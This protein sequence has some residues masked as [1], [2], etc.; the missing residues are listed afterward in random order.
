MTFDKFTGFVAIGNEIVF[1]SVTATHDVHVT[2][3]PDGVDSHTLAENLN[4]SA[5]IVMNLA[6]MYA[7]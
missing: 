2:I 6:N 3:V 1:R 5:N 7:R 4:A